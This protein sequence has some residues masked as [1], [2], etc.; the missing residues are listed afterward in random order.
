[1]KNFTFYN[2]TKIVFGRGTVAQLHELIP[3]SSRILITYGG[4]SAEKTGTLN[5]VRSA[6]QQHNIFEFGGIE[7]NPEY[8]TL[9]KAVILARKEQIDFILAVGG[10]SVLDGSKFIATA[11]AYD[12]DCWDILKSYGSVIKSAVPMGTVLTLPATGSEMNSGGVITRS[13]LKTKLAF[14]HPCLFPKFS[15][16]D[17]T[18]AFTL[19]QKQI[20]NGVV[21][22]FVHITE[23]YLTYP[24]D[25]M[26]Q[27]KF[28][29]SLLQILI[30]IGPQLLK[31]RHNY[32]LNANFM[33]VATL[34]L[35]GLI[36]AGVPQD[37]ATH[38][39]GH[40]LTALYGMDHG[41]TLA[42]VLPSLL[43]EKREEKKEKLLQ[44]AKNIWGIT[45]GSDDEKITLVIAKTRDFFEAMGIKTKL[46]DYGV[47][48]NQVDDI[49][50]QLEKHGMTALGE[51]NNITL[52][53]SRKILQKCF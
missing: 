35:N 37:W 11:I 13:E 39:I 17:P 45:N 52:E 46:S 27:D 40:E 36:G 1:M 51:N 5:E 29:E 21:D 38:L 8:E 25:G 18:K 2:P 43:E 6:L 50:A 3:L 33:W 16:L 44:Y 42:V 48:P 49:V 22:S 7:A 20:A 28:S 19:P 12:G 30:D 4:A 32:E 26:V 47:K 9:M 53:V 34:A 24:C 41:Q 15:I 10:G 23:Q 31:D 14:S